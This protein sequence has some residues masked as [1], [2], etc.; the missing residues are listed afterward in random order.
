MDI[1]KLIRIKKFDDLDPSEIEAVLSQF[2]EEEY[3]LQYRFFALSSALKK[4]EKSLV[5]TDLLKEK[6]HQ[7]LAKK[8]NIRLF[9]LRELKIAAFLCAF[10]LGSFLL[11]S[12]FKKSQTPSFVSEINT[13]IKIEKTI[14]IA[15]KNILKKQI[16]KGIVRKTIPQRLN[17]NEVDEADIR[18]TFQRKNPNLE[19]QT[20][21]D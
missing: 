4:T 15:P 2:S 10:V 13:E 5:P 14:D 8:S 1:E 9:S 17:I 18:L 6:I 7:K 12:T 16:K 11:F 19:W 21:E 20:E 3:R